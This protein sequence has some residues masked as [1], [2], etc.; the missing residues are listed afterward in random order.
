MHYL[1]HVP[2]E[3]RHGPTNAVEVKIQLW[4]HEKCPSCGGRRDHPATAGRMR[5]HPR[6]PTAQDVI[7]VRSAINYVCTKWLHSLFLESPGNLCSNWR[8]FSNRLRSLP[9]FPAELTEAQ[10]GQKAY[11]RSGSESMSWVRLDLSLFF[12]F[13]PLPLLLDHH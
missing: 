1:I 5:C 10:A 8:W 7:L 3:G 4:T 12:P 11:P 13:H 9:N 6:Y 2:T